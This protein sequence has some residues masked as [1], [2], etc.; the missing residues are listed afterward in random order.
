MKLTIATYYEDRSW[1]A[2]CRKTHEPGVVGWC[3]MK[4]SQAAAV[5]G[6]IGAMF[7]RIEGREVH[8]EFPE[9]YDR[10]LTLII[11]VERRGD[12]YIGRCFE[13]SFPEL[14]GYSGPRTTQLAAA[15]RA[16]GTYFHVRGNNEKEGAHA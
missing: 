7:R 15:K 11:E 9:F 6:A 2:S 13:E 14:R 8:D 5:S 16:L 10:E 4:R 3:G 1:F 12:K